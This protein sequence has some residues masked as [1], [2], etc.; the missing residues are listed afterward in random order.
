MV[1]SAPEHLIWNSGIPEPFQQ[2]LGPRVI[3]SKLNK[4]T[5]GSD[6]GG[7][8]VDGE[9]VGRGRLG[10]E[11]GDH[12]VV[13]QHLHL[14]VDVVGPAGGAS[15]RATIQYGQQCMDMCKGRDGRPVGEVCKGNN[16]IWST[17]HGYV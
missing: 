17:M 15:A 16:T 3:H 5:A 1:Q 9:V 7:A 8:L 11:G 4:G 14:V 6:V 13:A 10:D 12:G 2:I